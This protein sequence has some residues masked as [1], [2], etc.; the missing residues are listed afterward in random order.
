MHEKESA[1]SHSATPS[2][3]SAC[4]PG[5]DIRI[6]VREPMPQVLDAGLRAVASRDIGLVL[7]RPLAEG[8][9][10]A[11]LSRYA[12]LGDS[13]IVSARVAHAAPLGRRGWLVRCRFSSPLSE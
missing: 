4:C 11:V 9:S 10:V 8:C 13:R 1:L 3:K 6:L 2:R 7:D 5:K 12:S